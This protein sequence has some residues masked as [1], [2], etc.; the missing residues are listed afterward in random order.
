M[1]VKHSQ[2]DTNCQDRK[3]WKTQMRILYWTLIGE[4][5][6]QQAESNPKKPAEDRSI[7]QTEQKTKRSKPGLVLDILTG[8]SWTI[9]SM[10]VLLNVLPS[11]GA[12]CTGIQLE[13]WRVWPEKCRVG[14]VRRTMGRVVRWK[15]Y[16]HVF[17]REVCVPVLCPF[18]CSLGILTVSRCGNRCRGG[19]TWLNKKWTEFKTF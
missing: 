10:G 19:W 4:A 6:N 17:C 15:V 3:V 5:Q 14:V 9:A 8:W 18:P 11:D 2:T 12:R 13:F 7:G 1:S 16:V